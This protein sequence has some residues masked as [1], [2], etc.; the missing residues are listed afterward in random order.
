MKVCNDNQ[1][2]NEEDRTHMKCFKHYKKMGFRLRLKN[3]AINHKNAAI[4]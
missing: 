3:A 2:H 1:N 4:G